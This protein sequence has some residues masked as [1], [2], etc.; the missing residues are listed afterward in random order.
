M[1]EN[2]TVKTPADGP[3]GVA[4]LLQGLWHGLDEPQHVCDLQGRLGSGVKT[5]G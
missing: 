5:E 2:K 4:R 3:V 1:S